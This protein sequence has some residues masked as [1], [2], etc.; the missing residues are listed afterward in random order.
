MTVQKQQ[1]WEKEATEEVISFIDNDWYLR[2]IAEYLRA[3]GG[4]DAAAL[5]L[6]ALAFVAASVK[7]RQYSV[8]IKEAG[9]DV[10]SSIGYHITRYTRYDIRV[11]KNS[12]IETK[13]H[14]NIYMRF[15]GSIE[16]P[17]IEFLFLSYDGEIEHADLSVRVIPAGRPPAH[18]LWAVRRLIW[19]AA[20]VKITE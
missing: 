10:K 3:V 16:A 20:N 8:D 19:A 6:E 14:Y 13:I 15:L 11:R 5:E 9:I 2:R 7:A 17:Q 1:D 18:L 4:A 12:T